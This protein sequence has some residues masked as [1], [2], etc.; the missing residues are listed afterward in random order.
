MLFDESRV[1]SLAPDHVCEWSVEIELMRTFAGFLIFTSTYRMLEV[2][3]FDNKTGVLLVCVI[4]MFYDLINWGVLMLLIIA[5]GF[6]LVMHMLAPEYRLEGSPGAW[7]PFLGWFNL[8]LD[9]SSSGPFWMT[10]WG[11]L[12]FFEPGQG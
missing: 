7:R 3:T 2:P 12:G 9:I 8:D 5:P 1:S 6:G 10:F 11:L 4:N